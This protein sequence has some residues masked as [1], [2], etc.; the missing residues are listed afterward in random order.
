M[1]VEYAFAETDEEK[2]QIIIM[3]SE[4]LLFRLN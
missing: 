1:L 3:V 2:R 4:F